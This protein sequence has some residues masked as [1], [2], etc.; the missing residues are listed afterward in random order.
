MNRHLILYDIKQNRLL[1]AIITGILFMYSG[2]IINMYDPSGNEDLIKLA[3]LKMSPELIKAFGFEIEADSSLTSFI[4][5]YLYGMLM[6][7]LPVLYSSITANRLISGHVGHGD[8]TFLM[9]CPLS[10]SNIAISQG[11]FLLASTWLLILL[12]TGFSIILCG[13]SFPGLLDIGAFT[14]LNLSLAALMTLLS[15]ISFLASASSGNPRLSL[16]IGTGLPFLFY[17]LKMAADASGSSL[18]KH[19]TVFS[20]F[21]NTAIAGGEGRILY[22]VIMF[23]AGIL[24]YAIAAFSFTRR[25][26][27]V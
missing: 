27:P 18:L 23:C 26:L 7:V 25:D 16:G 2:I 3:S 21:E 20:L 11:A 17:I 22:M 14:K 19:M 1:F 8:M 5:S 9:S 24:L 15:G 6:L 4:S 12:C 10:R 13:H